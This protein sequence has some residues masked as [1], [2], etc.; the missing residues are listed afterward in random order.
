MSVTLDL[1]IPVVVTTGSW[2]Q[3]ILNEPG[4]I[5]QHILGTEGGKEIEIGTINVGDNQPP[6]K[7]IIVFEK[8][9]ISCSQQRLELYRTDRGTADDLYDFFG[10]LVELLPHTPVSAIGVNYCFLVADEV[11]AI[12][13]SIE[14]HEAFE[15]IGI[16]G[17]SDRTESIYLNSDGQLQLPAD[18][19]EPCILNLNR[20][21]D[22]GKAHVVFNFHQEV[23]G[24]AA[25]S[26]WKDQNPI[27]HWL[28]TAESILCDLYGVTEW[29]TIAF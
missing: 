12:S 5:A 2:N 17:I 14:T 8:F 29:E 4:W 16:V 20:Q 21:T 18:A 11:D 1:R 15:G 27:N 19:A 3:V 13:S 23:S 6:S 22:F 7:T 28:S 9:G 24:I 26:I 10:K 25:I